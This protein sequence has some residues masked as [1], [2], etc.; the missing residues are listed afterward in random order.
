MKPNEMQKIDASKSKSDE[1]V[2]VSVGRIARI[3]CCEH[4][5]S[6]V[7]VVVIVTRTHREREREKRRAEVN[8]TSKA[9]RVWTNFSRERER[10]RE[11]ENR[12]PSARNKKRTHL[13]RA[14]TKSCSVLE[15]TTHTSVC[16]ISSPR[17][18]RRSMICPFPLLKMR[19]KS[20]AHSPHECTRVIRYQRRDDDAHYYLKKRYV[21]VPKARASHGSR[22]VQA[23][24]RVGA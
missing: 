17:R 6:V 24:V 18:P 5:V 12:R 2:G 7:F 10:E 16:S 9:R 8:I 13:S 23:H 14:E 1:Y 15:R 22:F 21:R 4:F 20:E 19:S 3:S 11:R